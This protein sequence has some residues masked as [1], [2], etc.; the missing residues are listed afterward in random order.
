MRPLAV[1]TALALG[2]ALSAPLLCRAEITHP[3]DPARDSP[4]L[5]LAT[6]EPMYDPQL[7]SWQV[8]GRT[9]RDQID[10][11]DG[12]EWWMVVGLACLY[13]V[14][15]IV[16]AGAFVYVTALVI[17]RL[18]DDRG[19]PA[20]LDSASLASRRRSLGPPRGVPLLRF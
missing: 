6:D 13:T 1:A 17:G 18:R 10:G 5:R 2:T 15:V 9:S 7:P 19:D 12:P 14:P 16:F 20:R 4:T 8:E 11:Y 3:S